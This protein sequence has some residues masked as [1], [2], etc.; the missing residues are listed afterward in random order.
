NASTEQGIDLGFV[1]Q[2]KDDLD[3]QVRLTMEV[4]PHPFPD[5][6]DLRIISDCA[7]PEW[8]TVLV[9]LF[10]FVHP[11]PRLQA[12]WTIVAMRS[13]SRRS[14][15]TAL[16][17]AWKAAESGKI[18]PVTKKSSSVAPTGCQYTP[19]AEI[20]TSGMRSARDSATPDRANPR[21]ATRR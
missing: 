20:V 6:D 12:Q 3:G 1:T 8:G 4:L 19:A 14:S 10:C 18:S 13:P 15:R 11:C 2:V 21:R 7:E 16:S 9:E 5:R 17:T